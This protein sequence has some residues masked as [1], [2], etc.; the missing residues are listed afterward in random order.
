MTRPDLATCAACSVS[1]LRKI[2]A[3]ER[4]P[5]RQLARLLAECLQI[6][7]EEQS[8]FVDAAR[9]V[10]QVA[11]MG[12]AVPEAL[13]PGLAQLGEPLPPTSSGASLCPPWNLPAPATPFVGRE[14][15]LD[16]LVQLLGDAGCRLLTLL[17]PGGIGKTRLALEAA[18]LVWN[19]FRDGVFF[20]PLEDTESREH[21]ATAIGQAIGLSFSGPLDPRQQVVGFLQRRQALVF[22][23]NLEHLLGGVDVL[24]E[25]L[26]KAPA[27]KLMVTSRERLLLRGEWSFEVQGLPTPPEGALEAL[28]AYSATRLFVQR[29]KRARVDFQLSDDNRPHVVRICRLAEGMPLAIELAAAWTPVLSCREI[30]DEIERGLDILRTALRDAPERQRSMRAVFDHSWQLLTEEEQRVLRQL[31]VFRGGCRREAARVVANADLVM[32]SSLIAKSFLRRTSRDRFTMHDLVQQYVASRLSEHPDEADATRERHAGYYM[33]FVAGLE[34]DLKGSRQQGALAQLDAE[35]EN[36]RRAWRRAVRRG[37]VE[38]I[39]KAIRALWCFYDARGWFRE[40]EANFKWAGDVLAQMLTSQA[41]SDQPLVLLH[42]YIRAQQAWFL[43]RIGRFEEAAQLLRS[44]LDVLRAAE[45]GTLLV[46]ALQ[47]AGALDRLMGNYVQSRLY[48][49]EMLDYAQQTGDA[50]N[51]TIASGDIGLAAAGLGDYEEARARMAGTVASFRA[52]GDRRMLGVA[53]HHLGAISCALGM[54]AEARD[55][56]EESLTL[57]RAIGDRWIENMSLRELGNLA[58]ETGKQAHAAALF[59]D[60]L[61]LA[62]EIGEQWSTL[63]ALNCLGTTMLA[64]GEIDAAYQALQEGLSMAWQMQAIPDVLTALVGLAQWSARTALEE[65]TLQVTLSATLFIASHPAATPKAKERARCLQ[66]ELET[67]LSPV[68]IEAAREKKQVVSLEEL[69]NAFSVSK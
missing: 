4:R 34:G 49:E 16:R 56:L 57:S 32:L 36:I 52:L 25:V 5:S 23:D 29:A 69:A 26:E 20:V 51:A 14:A 2:E 38:D 13:I 50:W 7:S 31:S 33:D 43:L 11:R 3:D 39:R 48:H 12:P 63:Q 68:L 47:H 35:A 59:R 18:C 42:A 22:L 30:A 46:D 21:M 64:V 41:A 10:R 62:R 8:R 40:A 65:E 66:S 54:V 17:G 53:L 9:G 19:Q 44:S 58:W 37:N 45:A 61:A 1:A 55:Y 24:A 28:E 67:R 60:S 15:E 6:P 27:V